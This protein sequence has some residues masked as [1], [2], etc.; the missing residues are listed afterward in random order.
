MADRPYPQ[1][2]M[3]PADP[4]YDPKLDPHNPQYDPNDP[5]L[6]G[7]AYT[8][9]RSPEGIIT[10]N[11]PPLTGPQRPA[12]QQPNIPIQT[13]QGAPQTPTQMPQTAPN[14][15]VVGASPYANQALTG[16]GGQPVG[17]LPTQQPAP[18]LGSPLQPISGPIR[19]QINPLHLQA[20]AALLQR[21]RSLGV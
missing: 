13:A 15:G 9:P 4:N 18:N 16:G 12:P 8:G 2:P 1:H 3:D 7:G 11:Q 5:R 14:S 6:V 19:P 17:G 10:A 20:I 21:Y